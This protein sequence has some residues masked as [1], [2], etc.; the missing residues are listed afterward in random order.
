MIGTQNFIEGYWEENEY[1]KIIKEKYQ[2]EYD[3]IKNRN[4]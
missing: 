1:T 3:L 2:K 4:R